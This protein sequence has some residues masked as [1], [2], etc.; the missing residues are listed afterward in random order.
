MSVTSVDTNVLFAAVVPEAEGHEAALALLEHHAGDAD[1]AIS[2]LVLVE[3]YVL[4]RNPKVVKRPLPSAAAV[5]V[6]DAF[7]R[8]PRWR[9]A[10]HDREAMP[11]VWRRARVQGFAR[12]RI[13]DVR[14]AVGLR[15][16]GVTRF[17]TR[18]VRDFVDLGFDELIDPFS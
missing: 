10:D 18:N 4:L 15:R 1:L 8:H 6:V 5:D 11:E 13:F 3:L 9:R 14:L 2:E 7:R 12:T 16:A 17:V